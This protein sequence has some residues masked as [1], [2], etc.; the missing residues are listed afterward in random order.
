M[1][2]E[3]Y[4]VILIGT[5]SGGGTIAQ[6]LAPS[7]EKILLIERGDFI[8]KEKENWDVDE[9][10][11]KGRYRSQET[12]YD[13]DGHPFLPFTHYVVGGN[14][15]VYGAA[16]F[17]LREADFLETSH[18]T[19]TSPA[20]PI[21]YAQ[22]APYYTQAERL[23][24]VHGI[25]GS[26]LFE[27]PAAEP[28]PFGAIP[29]EPFAQELYDLVGKTGLAPFPIPMAVRL[30]QDN[31]YWPDAPTILGNFDGF[32]DPTE[33]KADAHVTGIRAALQYPNVQ[34]LTNAFVSRLITN[35]AGDRVT[36]V[37]V[38]QNGTTKTYQTGVVIVAAGAV[39]SAALLLRSATEKHPNGLA[40]GSGQVGRNYMSHL[41][42]CLIAFT[43]D[44]LNTASFQK[45]F[46]IGDY[47]LPSANNPHALGEIQLMG[48]N[49]PATVLSLGTPFFP[50]KDAAWLSAHSIDFWLTAEDFPDPDNRVTLTPDGHIRL[51]YHRERNNVFAYGQL[52][53]KLKDLFKKLGT[54]D[55]AFGTVYWGGY[56]LGISGVSHQ[57]GTLRFGLDPATSVLDVNCKAHELANLY[58]VDGSFFPSSGAY[59]P[60]LT[61]AANALRVGEHLLNHVL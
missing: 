39:N 37:R 3:S 31:T 16:S 28:Y 9:V 5:G 56:D 57:C 61:I 35:E 19:G 1:Q 21:S 7:G 29:V 17:R 14:S 6:K 2:H 46:C 26:D 54:L 15:K 33:A 34:L 51:T 44:K 11:V 50:D 53:Q 24:S 4:D 43:P 20:W 58:V 18:P 42:G 38:E 59:N 36:G 23:F 10:V 60:S 55:P 52:K 12:W 41:N 22:L 30:A 32:P 48:K 47:Y 49:D 13:K 27:P 25:R 40:N 45:Y 8:P